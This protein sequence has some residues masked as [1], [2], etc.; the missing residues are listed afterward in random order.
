M[1]QPFQDTRGFFGKL[2]KQFNELEQTITKAR[3]E[4]EQALLDV[5]NVLEEKKT[6]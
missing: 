1:K 3:N 6:A 2:E 4:L 5:K